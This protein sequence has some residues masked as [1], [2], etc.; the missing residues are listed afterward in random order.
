MAGC[1]CREAIA[2]HGNLGKSFNLSAPP[3][4]R[5]YSGA[6]RMDAQGRRQDSWFKAGKPWD[7]H[8][9]QAGTERRLQGLPSSCPAPV[10]SQPWGAGCGPLNQPG[11]LWGGPEPPAQPCLGNIWQG[12]HWPGEAW[13]SLKPPCIKQG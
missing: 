13:M 6:R 12:S 2:P 8:W 3:R 4:R 7:P 5:H 1:S 10:E 9:I 11:R